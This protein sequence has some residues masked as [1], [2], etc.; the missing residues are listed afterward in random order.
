[1]AK[2]KYRIREFKPTQNQTG[3]HSFF[4]EAVVDNIIT[5][6]ELG[7]KD[8][9]YVTVPPALEMVITPSSKG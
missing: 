1:M 7:K 5:N 8:A 4:A 2:V 6:K 3:G 9:G